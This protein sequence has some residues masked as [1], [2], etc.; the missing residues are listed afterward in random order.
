MEKSELVCKIGQMKHLEHIVSLRLTSG[1]FAVYQQ[2]KQEKKGDFSQIESALSTA[3]PMDGFPAKEQ[4]AEQ[5]LHPG[6]SVDV[7]LAELRR[8]SVLFGGM[9]NHGMAC[10]FV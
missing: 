7:Y 6:E 5:D 1:V 9:S 3:F 8:L 2:L 10:A 4:F